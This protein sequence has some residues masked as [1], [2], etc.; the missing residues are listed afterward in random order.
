MRN[1]M[2]SSRP[3]RM[4]SVMEVP[5]RRQRREKV[6]KNHHQ[7]RNMKEGERPLT[8]RAGCMKKGSPSRLILVK[9]GDIRDKEKT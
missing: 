1:G 3:A 9:F 7:N 2:S 4:L 8:L 6:L 5:E